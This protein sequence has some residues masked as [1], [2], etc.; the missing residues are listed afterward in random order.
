MATPERLVIESMF[1]VADKDGNDVPFILNTAQAAIDSRLT[2]RDVIPK[3]RQEGVSTYFL[4][5]NTVKCLGKRNTRAVVISHDEKSTQR[6]LGKVHY[7]L[8]NV[9]GPKPVIKNSS[10]NEITFP[11]TNSAFYIGT[12]GAK[13]FGRGDTISSLH[14]SEVAY[15]P[16]PKGLTAGLFQ[17][18]PRDGEISIESTGNGTGNWYHKMSMRAFDGIGRYRLHF[19]DWQSFPE[20]TVELGKAQAEEIMDTLDPDL[21]EP[22]LVTQ[23]GLS[24]GQIQW[25]REKLEELEYD[26][27]LFEQEYPMTLDQCFQSAGHSLFQSVT[28][29][30]TP[31]WELQG[32][33]FH[34]LKGHPKVKGRYAF[35][36]DSSGGV[37]LDN[38]VIQ[39]ID[40]DTF[41]QVGELAHNKIQPDVLGHKAA[42][43]GKLFN[44]AFITVESN[45][46]GLVT[47][48]VLL[49]NYPRHLLYRSNKT[50]DDLLSVYGHNTSLKSKPLLVGK[51]RV[52]LKEG[53]HIH[54]S[55]LNGELSTFVE[56]DTGKLEADEGCMDDRVM[57][58]LKAFWGIERAQM[59][60]P[61]AGDSLI[62]ASNSDPFT[63]EN[64]I[65][66][67]RGRRNAF[68]IPAQVGGDENLN[69]V[70]GFGGAFS[71]RI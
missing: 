6:M 49:D 38:A 55:A 60:V 23:F 57:A 2:G 31:E 19:L 45:N 17:A 8:D 26:K 62:I 35:G 51:G 33:H 43:L 66:E 9:R 12:A 48:K 32:P 1:M 29:I 11:K 68:P 61:Q 44:D 36:I 54:S 24:A 40:L 25:R 46:H 50:S 71:G 59:I 28:F 65:D 58:L 4:A 56:K 27:K 14:C 67:L 13:K 42:A 37:E 5:R 52:L 21:D 3:A 34:V 70:Y 15:W 18:V 16:D 7:F 53:F 63:L 20:Y 39:I 22:R 10:K 64:I 69:S 47:L 30:P 41:E